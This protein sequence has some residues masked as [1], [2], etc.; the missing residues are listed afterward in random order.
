MKTRI[1]LVILFF[2]LAAVTCDYADNRLK[3]VNNSNKTI[4]VDFS[5]DTL[6]EE[7]ENKFIGYYL[8]NKILPSDTIIRTMPGSMRG[9]E[10]LIEHSKN[11]KLNMY[12]ISFDTLNKY[13]DWNYI[14]TKSLYEKY[15]YSLE[16]LEISNWI[17]EYK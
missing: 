2:I 6:L 1:I 9:W 10:L 17:I 14:R 11:D 7:M 12:V 5:A 8:Q 13:K 4:V 16:E 15:E 3:I